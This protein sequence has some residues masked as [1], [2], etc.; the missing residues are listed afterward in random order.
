MFKWR[1]Y[2][3]ML[4]VLYTTPK[5]RQRDNDHDHIQTCDVMWCDDDDMDGGLLSCFFFFLSCVCLMCGGNVQILKL[6]DFDFV[7]LS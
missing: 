4:F 7:Y 2:Q 5:P 1:V 3:T 6:V